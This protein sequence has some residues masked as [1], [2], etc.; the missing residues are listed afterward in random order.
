MRRSKPIQFRGATG[1]IYSPPYTH[2]HTGIL[3][4]LGSL[5]SICAYAKNFF[6]S[7]SS[8]R[9]AAAIQIPPHKGSTHARTHTTLASTT[10]HYRTAGLPFSSP[11]GLFF[12]FPY[13]H[14][15]IR[16][17]IPTN[18]T[19]KQMVNIKQSTAATAASTSNRTC[20]RNRRRYAERVKR[21]H[22]FRWPTT[23]TTAMWECGLTEQQLV[24]GVRVPKKRRMW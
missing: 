13:S 7:R 12:P 4:V 17:R 24:R 15:P 14:R 1:A 21:M 22:I 23:T 8:S 11:F 20:L 10:T 19:E 3:T 2:T 5:S 6:T 9:S 16:S 18:N